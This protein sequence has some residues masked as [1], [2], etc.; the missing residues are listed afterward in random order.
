MTRCVFLVIRDYIRCKE[1]RK[2]NNFH[3]VYKENTNNF[4]NYEDRV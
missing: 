2:E 4:P 1:Y 3:R